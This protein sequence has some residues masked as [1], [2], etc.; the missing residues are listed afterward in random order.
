MGIPD[1][2]IEHGDRSEL[3]AAL[4]LNTAGIVDECRKLCLPAAASGHR[5]DKVAG[6]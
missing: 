3:L 5:E 4:G 6:R 1:R 2:F